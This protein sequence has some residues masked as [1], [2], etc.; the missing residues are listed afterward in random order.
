MNSA[1]WIRRAQTAKAGMNAFAELSE[2]YA[3]ARNATAGN[4]DMKEQIDMVYTELVDSKNKL[5]AVQ[6]G[7]NVGE[8]RYSLNDIF[9]ILREATNVLSGKTVTISSEDDDGDRS[10]NDMT[11]TEAIAMMVAHEMTWEH[12]RLSSETT[13]ATK[14]DVVEALKDNYYE[15]VTYPVY[16]HFGVR[17][18]GGGKRKTRKHRH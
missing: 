7:G 4:N 18:H 11:L 15:E 13:M 14:E 6:A 16:E 17:F 9:S 10:E 2:T 8:K 3:D 5:A 12:S 1:N